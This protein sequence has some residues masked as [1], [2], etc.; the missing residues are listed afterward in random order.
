[1]M[2]TGRKYLPPRRDGRAEA[3]RI[4]RKVDERRER[5]AYDLEHPW[6]PM[7]E[8]KSGGLLCELLF[9]DMGGNHSPRQTHFFLDDDGTWYSVDPPGRSYNKPMNWRRKEVPTKLSLAKRE[10][11]KAALARERR[12]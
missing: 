12:G 2:V 5:E 10:E 3:D 11:I 6:R 1:M 9:S 7:S 4:I 8:A